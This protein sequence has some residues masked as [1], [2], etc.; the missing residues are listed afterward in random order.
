VEHKA[1]LSSF[2]STSHTI[3]NP[4]QDVEIV[5]G[6]HPSDYPG[7]TWP[8]DAD[9]ADFKPDSKAGRATFRHDQKYKWSEKAPRPV[10]ETRSKALLGRHLRTSQTWQPHRRDL[11][12]S[13]L[14]QRFDRSH[15]AE[16]R[17]RQQ[18]DDEGLP[19]RHE[20]LLQQQGPQ[21]DLR[22]AWFS[23]VS[24]SSSECRICLSQCR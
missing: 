11:P 8:K 4:G 20:V 16:A 14:S 18:A 22:P 23:P 12:W 10:P 19:G 24:A 17:Q 7:S 21:C 13:R 5:G 15:L 6:R 1:E 2:L 9:H 3:W